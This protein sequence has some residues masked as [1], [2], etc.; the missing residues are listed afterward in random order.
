LNKFTLAEELLHNLDDVAIRELGGGSEQDLSNLMDDILD[1]IDICLSH[2]TPVDS[3]NIE[4]L[5]SVGVTLTEMLRKAS[6][7][8]FIMDVMTD[9]ELTPHIMEWGN[10]TQMYS[11]L[12]VIAARFHAKSFTFSYAYPLWKAYRY[13]YRLSKRM[14]PIKDRF[15]RNQ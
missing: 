9:F 10:L 14:L 13:G 15:N 1:E 7:N 6:F 8:Y 5:E 4:N 2:I 3:D 12:C 11:R